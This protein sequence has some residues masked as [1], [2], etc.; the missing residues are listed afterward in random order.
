MII[1][2]MIDFTIK[3]YKVIQLYNLFK[4]HKAE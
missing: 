2:K 4:Q 3:F 1:A